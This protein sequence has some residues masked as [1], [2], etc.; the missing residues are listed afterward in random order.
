MLEEVIDLSTGFGVAFLPALLLAIPC[1][2]LVVVPT[3][4]LLLALALPLALI[5][6]V[7]AA[8]ILLVRRLRRRG[9]L[10]SLNLSQ[11]AERRQ[12]ARAS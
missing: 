5:G 9:R 6:A 1:I 2:I 12:P 10:T 3:A 4:I 7:L 8:P 11:T